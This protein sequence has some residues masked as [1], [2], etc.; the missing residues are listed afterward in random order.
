MQRF[1]LAAFAVLLVLLPSQQVVHADQTLFTIE[2]LGVTTGGFVPTVTGVNASG[3]ASGFVSTP[4]G[5]RAVRYTNGRGWEYLPGLDTVDSVGNG[6]NASGDVVGYYF[7]PTGYRG[8]RFRDGSGV[9]DIQPMNGGTMTLA[10]GIN[11]A[12]DV[13]GGG[14]SAAGFGAFI[15]SPG[16]PATALPSLGGSFSL[17]CGI[18]DARQVAGS[19]VTADGAQQHAMLIDPVAGAVDIGSFDGS[20][21]FSTACA[22]D[23]D[24]RVG[25][26]ADHGG[27]ARAFAYAGRLLKDLD[28]FAAGSSNVESTAGGYNAGWYRR[29]DGSQHAFVY[30]AA[31]GAVDLNAAIAPDLG[32]V[33][34]Q[35]KGVTASGQIVGE[36]LLNGVATTF[37]L[38][39]LPKDTTPPVFSS[40][41]ATPSTIFPPKGQKVSVTVTVAATDDS[42]ATPVCKL[43]SVSGPGVAGVDFDVT[44]GNT[45]TVLA[46]GGRTYTMNEICVD[47]ANN[48][49]PAS[50]DVTVPADTTAPAISSLTA[51]PSQVWPPNGQLVPVSVSVTATDNVDDQPACALSGIT[52]TGA[53]ADDFAIRDAL[54]AVVRA[55]GGR[56]YVLTVGCADTAGNR[57]SSSVRVVVPADTTAPVITDLYASP[58]TIWPPNGKMVP[59]TV[60]ASATD[61]VD[62]TP[63]CSLTS[64]AGG[65]AGDAVI[66]GT[67]TANVRALKNND[68]SDRSYT[69]TVTCSDRASNK[70]TRAVTVTVTKDDS[71]SVIYTGGH[72]GKGNGGTPN[73]K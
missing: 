43:A 65:S 47:A 23:A 31:D 27:V 14:D 37:R 51:T 68:N 64:I 52:S 50:V 20:T 55:V 71:S 49:A 19:W 70:S 2:D 40:L 66:T 29:A 44:G 4:L 69:L 24:G 67:F 33:L 26:Q 12:G 9:E 8:F 35:A 73:H 41:T 25:G 62:A 46:V 22:I 15:S 6:I 36:G 10:F 42:G 21:G 48:V 34:V 61:D 5:S 39:P 54:S 11:N 60:A 32:W 28:A 53:T 16:L 1:T 59:V 63:S 72:S 38:T 18:N 7:S 56:T 57:S 17:G 58:S 13:V 3:Q 45:A 30:S